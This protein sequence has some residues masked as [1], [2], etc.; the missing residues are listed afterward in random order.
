VTQCNV[1]RIC[2]GLLGVLLAAVPACATVIVG[3]DLGELSREA[4]AIV[5]GR[6]VSV[7]ARWTDDRRGIETLVTLAA[8]SYLKGGLGETVTFRVPGGRLGR[9]R[10][11]VVGAPRFEADQQVIVFLGHH[12]PSIPHVLGL[13]QGVYHVTR[14]GTT[15]AVT[16][17]PLVGTT[18]VQPVVRGDQ[19]RRP[20]ALAAFE[21]QVRELV[22]AGGGR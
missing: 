19:D 7:D 6:V 5:R 12:G 2:T 8:E 11:I 18:V 1:W 16:P 14:H 3:A 15:W 21:Q 17:P 20:A 10:S 22:Q 13:N 9:L 4:G